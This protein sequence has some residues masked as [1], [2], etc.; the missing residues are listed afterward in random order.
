MSDETISS[1]GNETASSES[2]ALDIVNNPA[3]ADHAAL[4]DEN[5]RDHGR[6][7]TLVESM[8]AKA[9]PALDKQIKEEQQAAAWTGGPQE[10]GAPAE[11]PGAPM[12]YVATEAEVQVTETL[13]SEWGDQFQANIEFGGDV[14]VKIFPTIHDLD[15]FTR[16]TGILHDPE[17]LGEVMRV[18]A[19]IGRKMR[20]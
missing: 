8:F 13:R 7:K 5:H 3:N 19:K 4:H 11:T 12:N 2:A 17:M 6:V 18:V 15:N 1:V 16:Q 10:E 9:N 14:L 20:K